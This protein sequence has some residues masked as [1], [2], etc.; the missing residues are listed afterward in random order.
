MG[1][2]TSH[3]NN[4]YSNGLALR[5]LPKSVAMVESAL[6]YIDITASKLRG[7]MEPRVY[8]IIV[9]DRS[10]QSRLHSLHN[11]WLYTYCYDYRSP[12]VYSKSHLN[13]VEHRAHRSTSPDTDANHVVLTLY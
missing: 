6:V 5:D 1:L 10:F 9:H 3:V 13:N 2:D 7:R 8:D 4:M 11:V 12:C